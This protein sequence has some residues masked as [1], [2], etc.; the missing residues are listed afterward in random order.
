MRK[1]YSQY[2]VFLLVLMLI[3]CTQNTPMEAS[4]TSVSP[5]TSTRN[6]Q[7]ATSTAAE[8][9]IAT[10][11]LAPLPSG[12]SEMFFQGS[13]ALIGPT[14]S[15]DN[16][17][18]LNLENDTEQSVT[19][20]GYGSLAWSPDGQWIAFDGGKPLSQQ[21]DIYMIR[22]DSSQ[23]KRLTNSPQG[24][25]DLDWSPDGKSLVYTYDNHIQPSDL[26]LISIENN[27]SVL[28]TAT[29]GYESHPTWSP[30]GR[31]IAYLFAE[32][33]NSPLELW[34]MDSD[35]KNSKRLIDHPISFSRIG[36]SPDGKWIA[37]VSGETSKDCGNIY[38]VQSNGDELTQLTH[39]SGCATSLVWS[40]DGK[41]I[42]FIGRNR[43]S[44]KGW[45]VYIMDNKGKNIA[46]ITDEA[47]LSIYDIDWT[48]SSSSKK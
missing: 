20:M 31:Q 14:R 7:A 22:P 6:A 21:T 34:T 9:Q 29:E 30:D 44:R 17:R 8:V 35:G 15:E 48:Q 38:V 45:Q 4:P 32:S 43:T 27:S 16:I 36:W 41:S 13:I 25:S 42:A 46:A 28:L 3:G 33:N 1:T 40:P 39:L 47:E 11:S 18:I 37:F 12:G 26:A 2:I 10:A 19:G 5:S 24:K 23:L